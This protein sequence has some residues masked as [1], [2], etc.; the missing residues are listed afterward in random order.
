MKRAGTDMRRTMTPHRGKGAGRR[1]PGPAAALW[2]ALGLTLLAPALL[3]LAGHLPGIGAW[4]PGVGWGTARADLVRGTTLIGHP[5]PERVWIGEPGDR[6]SYYRTDGGHPLIVRGPGVM[7]LYVR[8]TVAE[9]SSEPETLSIRMTGFGKYGDQTWSAV[10]DRSGVSSFGG[11]LPGHPTG[12]K[13]ITI[14]VPNGLQQLILTATARSGR[15]TYVRAYHDGPAPDS[16]RSRR[17][18][19]KSRVFAD[20]SYPSYIK[21]GEPGKG[22]TY[23]FIDNSFPLVLQ[24]PGYLRMYVRG[25]T[26]ETG[27]RPES[28]RV[29]LESRDGSIRHEWFPVE[30]KSDEDVFPE[31]V[32]GFP[33]DADKITIAFPAGRHEYRLTGTSASGRPVYLRAFYNGPRLKVVKK[34]RW[35]LDTTV[36]VEAIYDDNICRYSAENLD[37]FRS[38]RNNEGFAIETDDDIIVN[39]SLSAELRRPLLFGK[40]TRLRGRF[41]R[42]TYARNTIKDNHEW[43]VRFRQHLRKYDYFEASYTYA[44]DS[45]IKELRDRKPFLS[46]TVDLEYLHFEITRNAFNFGYRWWI[47]SWLDTKFFVD[48]V[49]RFYNRPFM[50][51]DLW[52]WNFMTETDVEYKRLTF[53]FRY[54]YRNVKARGYDEVDETLETSDNDGDGSYENDGYRLRITYE[55]KRFPY[56]PDE[57]T[58]PALYGILK[59]ASYLDQALVAIKTDDIYVQYDYQR[60]FYTS[61]RPLEADPLH[62]GRQDIQ[63]QPRLVWSSQELW[64]EIELEAGVRYTDRST[65]APATVI[66]EDDPSEEKAYT[67]TRYWLGFTRDF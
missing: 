10:L 54:E 40:D 7:D 41:Q 20:I 29:V 38:G 31:G 4:L 43:Q 39:T 34:P 1:C 13:K 5:A 19:P 51:N 50:E 36:G 22:R 62:V 26:D 61:E 16:G 46:Q 56:R 64:N 24:G 53:R 52:E 14:A 63:N 55:P 60:R 59:L 66:G 35:R 47:N 48:R 27:S 25:H 58:H 67:A 44:P 57:D 65:D 37:E 11:G 3:A 49:L 9:G 32:V 42:W 33:T 28:L 17:V 8:G 23:Y 18:R 2:L 45:Y 30:A 12:S 21:I 6:S 15:P